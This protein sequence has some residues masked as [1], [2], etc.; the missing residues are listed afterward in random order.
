MKALWRWSWLVTLPVF[1]FLVIWATNTVH[2]YRNF[3]L[4]YDVSPMRVGLWE[5]GHDEFRWLVRRMRLAVFPNAGR[6]EDHEDD[7]RTISLYVTDERLARLN[8]DLPYTG[9]E[10]VKGGLWDGAGI[11]DVKV[12]YRGDFARHW[13]F[14]KKS[15]R[16]KTDRA[17]LFEGLRSF[18]LVVPKF[19]EHLNNFLAY[20]LAERLGL[21]VPRS[22]LVHVAVNGKERGVHL[23]VEQLEELTLRSNGYM[24]G[25]LYSGELVAKDSRRGVTNW[26]FDHPGLWEKIAINNHYPEAHYRPLE[27]LCVLLNEFPSE[28]TSA[29]LAGLLDLEA[30]ARF[31][32]FESLARTFHYDLAHNWR[33]YYDLN[34][35]KFVPVVWDPV[36]WAK[37]FRLK[38]GDKGG[39]DVVVTRLHLAL[40]ENGDFL[41]ARFDVLDEFYRTGTAAGFLAEVD[42]TILKMRSAIRV[43]PNLLPPSEE[44]V[45]GEMDA[46]RDQIA[47]VLER[48]EAAYISDPGRVRWRPL[49][50][51]HG[52]LALSVEGQRT[53]ER[54][55]VSFDRPVPAPTS[56]TLRCLREGETVTIDVTGA[57]K[58]DGHRLE[59]E[60][61]LLPKRVHSLTRS[62]AVVLGHRVQP[63][64]GYYE[65]TFTGLP[66]EAAPVEVLCDRGGPAL[67]AAERVA[68][69]RRMDL[70]RLY[71]IVPER[72][73]YAPLFWSGTVEIEGLVELERDLVIEAGTE[74][75]MHPGASLVTRGRVRAEGSRDRPILFL[76]ASGEPGAAPWGTVALQGPGTSGSRFLHCEFSAGSGLKDELR[77]YSAMFSVHDSSDVRIEASTFSDSLL[78]DDMVHAVYSSIAFTDC[79]FRRSL[80]DAVDLDI[81][82]ATLEGCVFENSGN[83]AI[84]L[85]TTQ[86]VV[87]DTVL[88]D[89]G[90]KGISTGEGSELFAVNNVFSGNAIGVQ[91]KDSSEAVLLNTTFEG[92][93]L[94]VDA[95]KKNWR[96]GAGGAVRV[97][98]SLFAGN[99]RAVT[100]DRYSSVRLSDCYIDE[101]PRPDSKGRV[102][103]A[104]SVDDVEREVAAGPAEEPRE[105]ESV[106]GLRGLWD[107]AWGRVDFSRRGAQRD[108]G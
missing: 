87:W 93:A 90:D 105:Y 31:S 71:S 75:R 36:G 42:A 86:A 52:S 104:E 82:R 38:P 88:R 39:L 68:S 73:S 10:Y 33:L 34:R 63:G 94:A 54:V 76:P 51:G 5:L 85:M 6:G 79:T 95:Y 48:V 100:A 78:V 108:D 20:R 99:A 27:R 67:Q 89:N 59:L 50:A 69:L 12:R 80:S 26:V 57:V 11:R 13:A 66:A 96:Y 98:N 41:R 23:L 53:V 91:V 46:L 101:L 18:N 3:A 56:A 70:G 83:D 7:L 35:G 65:L 102:V 43:D 9:F 30:W 17:A 22:E 25:D 28:Q 103:L 8:S 55:L 2:T 37:S 14:R 58:V 61:G 106:R 32:A 81:C 24:P 84:D 92:N 72:T 29:E 19:A 97:E 60:L 21:L 77:E 47:M 45:R 44:E 1:I 64:R 16:V 40:F 15:L 62:T 4:R 74:I 49:P 107:E